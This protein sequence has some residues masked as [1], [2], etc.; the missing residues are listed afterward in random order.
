M[1]NEVPWKI[2]ML[3]YLAATLRPLIFLQKEEPLSPCNFATALLTACILYFCPLNF[4][5]HFMKWRTFRI[6]P[7][8]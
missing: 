1:S 4:A 5:T 2:W 3:V 6:S 7:I 8:N